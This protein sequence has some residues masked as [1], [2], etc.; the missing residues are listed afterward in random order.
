MN[1]RINSLGRRTAVASAFAIAATSLAA[2]HALALPQP[3]RKTFTGYG[4]SE[5]AAYNDAL[6]KAAAASYG[7]CTYGSASD[8]HGPTYWTATVSCVQILN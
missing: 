8:P 4:S 3:P 2:P 6:S 5:T 1:R 7:S